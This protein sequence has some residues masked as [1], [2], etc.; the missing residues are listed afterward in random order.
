MCPYGQDR[1]VGSI[2][3]ITECTN[4][5][6]WSYLDDWVEC[7]WYEELALLLAAGEKE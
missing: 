1:M 5:N 6:D 4:S 3:C 2:S 7:S